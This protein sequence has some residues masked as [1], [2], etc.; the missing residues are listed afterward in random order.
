M[1]SSDV[2][3]R[4]GRLNR[5]SPVGPTSFPAPPTTRPQP[6]RELPPTH[7]PQ[8]PADS[9]NVWL[10]GHEVETVVG[11]HWQ[12]DQPLSQLWPQSQRYLRNYRQSR[13][14]GQPAA[15]CHPQLEQLGNG[16]PH[17]LLLLD[18]ETCGFS[19]SMVFLIGVLH[20]SDDQIQVRQ[21]L[22]RDYSEERA[23]LQSLWQLVPQKRMLVTY[24]G[25]SFDWPFV[26]DRSILHRI[27]GGESRP[28]IGPPVMADDWQHCDVLHHARRRWKAHLPNCRL[29]TLEWHVCGRRR[30]GDIPGRLI[31]DAYHDFVRTGDAWQIRSILHHNALD[32][33]TLFQLSL[34]LTCW[35]SSAESSA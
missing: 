29:Q 21:F 4:L 10:A 35:D 16:F 20:Q 18:L 25:K 13:S 34:A 15:N 14:N 24:N 2:L 6:P 3:A 7:E 9:A 12:V 19:G 33:V 5:Q 30:E 26:L 28:S 32:L 11:R 23:I 31:P 1:L 8:P 27:P 17:D 22:A